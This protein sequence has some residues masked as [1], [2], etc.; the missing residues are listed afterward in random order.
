VAESKQ[1]SDSIKQA[2]DVPKEDRMRLGKIRSYRGDPLSY[3]KWAEY[4]GFQSKGAVD[5]FFKR[6]ESRELID[7]QKSDSAAGG[8]KVSL[9]PKGE[10]LLVAFDHQ[11]TG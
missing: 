1:K 11:R 2:L 10:K 8:L 4:L 5:A 9:T 3:S 7:R 6:M